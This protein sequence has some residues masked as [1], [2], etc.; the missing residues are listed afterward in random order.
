MQIVCMAWQHLLY[1]FVNVNDVVSGA[2]STVVPGAT[3]TL[4]QVSKVSCLHA[5]KFRRCCSAALQTL[6]AVPTRD[7][8]GVCSKLH[9]LQQ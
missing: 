1:V 7:V 4:L 3:Q 9:R 8:C 5:A 2:A 6:T